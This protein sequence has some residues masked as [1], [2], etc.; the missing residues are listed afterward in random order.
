VRAAA[1]GWVVVQ[2]PQNA[3]SGCKPSAS[4][5][6]L[7]SAGATLQ[8][9]CVRVCGR[10]QAH[11]VLLVQAPARGARRNFHSLEVREGAARRGRPA[12]PRRQTPRSAGGRC[13]GCRRQTSSCSLPSGEPGLSASLAGASA[14]ASPRTGSASM[15]TARAAAKGP[16]QRA[17]PRLTLM[18]AAGS[19]THARPPNNSR[20]QRQGTPQSD[21]RRRRANMHAHPGSQVLA[22][23]GVRAGGA[24]A[25][26]RAACAPSA[27]RRPGTRATRRPGRGVP[28]A[29][30]CRPGPPHAQ[31]PGR[32]PP[33]PPMPL[34]PPTWAPRPRTRASITRKQR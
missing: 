20:A 15:A 32:R 34:R 30:G 1:Q 5:S 18:L 28:A 8:Q 29:P 14:R 12:A 13:A 26:R 33:R 25:R 7:T 22:T 17:R 27:P 2:R 31:P 9:A 6:C 3:R 19:A 4:S 23:E 16:R 11:Q 21:A 24:T 10:E